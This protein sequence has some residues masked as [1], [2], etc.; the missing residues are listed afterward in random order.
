MFTVTIRN[1]AVGVSVIAIG[2][3]TNITTISHFHVINR[4][5][6]E[7]ANPDCSGDSIVSFNLS[8]IVF[9]KLSVI[10]LAFLWR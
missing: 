9:I 4:E 10:G 2:I 7:E 5:Q 6:F 8:V 1:I 3:A